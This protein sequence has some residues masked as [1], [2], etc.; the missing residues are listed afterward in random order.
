MNT[1]R[2]ELQKL[3]VSRADGGELYFPSTSLDGVIRLCE[4]HQ[5]FIIGIEGFRQEGAYI[6]PVSDA[7]ADFSSLTGLQSD[8]LASE[9]VKAAKSFLATCDPN[10]VSI[11]AFVIDDE[12]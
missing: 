4:S 3:A 6:V 11:W 12:V 2:E 5:K 8:I 9:S 1:F 7:I 10:D